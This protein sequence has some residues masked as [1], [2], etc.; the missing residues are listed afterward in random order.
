MIDRDVGFDLEMSDRDDGEFSRISDSHLSAESALDA[1]QIKALVMECVGEGLQSVEKHL[2]DSMRSRF[3]E[4][5]QLAE[6]AACMGGKRL[7]PMLVLL[8]AQAASSSSG[9]PTE[10][11]L[12]DLVRI[13]AAVELVHTA[14]LAHDDVMDEA[15]SRRH[16]PTLFHIAGNSMAIL[17]G[18][19]LFTKAYASAAGCRSP[20]VARRISEAATDLCEGELRQQNSVG[21]WQMS[22]REYASILV[23]KTASLCSVGCHLGAWQMGGPKSQQLSLRSYGKWVG[24][25]FQIFDDWLDYWGD[26]CAGKTLGTDLAQLKPTLPLL[27]YLR[28]VDANS[29]RD[30]LELLSDQDPKRLCSAMEMI[31]NSQAGE[32]TLKTAR[33]LAARSIECLR[34][35]PESPA[36]RALESVALFSV[37]RRV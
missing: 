36:K 15:E 14:S 8:S 27:Y 1:Q 3:Q 34:N 19:F 24:L 26:H 35:L 6:K 18:D 4:V 32:Q 28:S 23:Q 22:V 11:D 21:N 16:Q 10:R 5:S 33:D 9:R 29:R 37:N 7:R 12:R 25:A 17:V 20:V 13:A 2:S 31:R 30:F